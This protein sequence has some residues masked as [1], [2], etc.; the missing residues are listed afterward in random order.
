MMIEAAK[1]LRDHFGHPEFRPGQRESIEAT[2]QGRDV[3]AVMPTGSG[4][5]LCYQVP[6]LVRDGPAVVVSPLIALMKDQVDALQ[7]AGVAATFINS[8]IDSQE[9]RRRMEGMASGRWQLIYV[10]P[11]RLRSPTFRALLRRV[12]LGLLA[13]DEAH[14][15]SSWGHDFRPDYLRVGEMVAAARPAPVVACTATATPEVRDDIVRRL[16]LQ[17]PKVLVRGFRRDNLFLTVE[18][19]RGADDKIGRALGHLTAALAGEGSALVYCSTRKRS[20]EVADKLRRERIAAEAYHAGIA[21]EDRKGVQDRFM[22]GG[23]RCVVAT[24]AFG[25]GVDK[26]DVRLVIHHDLPGSPEAYYQEVGRAGRDGRPSR[27]VLLFNHG[28]LHVRRFLIEASN[29]PEEVVRQV[30]DVLA[31]EAE[32]GGGGGVVELSPIAIA[33]R[34]SLA[35]GDRQV[36]SAL[37]ALERAEL[38]E[39]GVPG[40]GRP[41]FQLVKRAP[42]AVD[43][44]LAEVAGA[45]RRRALLEALLRR[46]GFREGDAVSVDWGALAAEAGAEEASIRRAATALRGA[47]LVSVR[48]GFSGRAMLLRSGAEPDAVSFTALKERADREHQKLRRMTIYCTGVQCRHGFI[49][50]HFGDEEAGACGD[51]CDICTDAA[52]R[53]AEGDAGGTRR[54]TSA[55]DPGLGRQPEDLTDDQILSIRKA[56]SAVARLRGRYGLGRVAAVLTGGRDQK[57]VDAGLDQLPTYGALSRWRRADVL[58]LLESLVAAGCCEVRGQEYPLITLSELGAEVMHARQPPPLGWPALSATSAPRPT[59]QNPRRRG[60]PAS[61]DPPL[62]RE[63]QDLLDRL[64]QLRTA[65]ARD[66]S[67][68]AYVI[69]TDRTLIDMARQCPQDDA[70]LLQVHGIGPQKVERYGA[71]FLAAVRGQAPP[72]P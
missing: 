46:P 65:L 37:I 41:A 72:G 58:I 34:C 4:K 49:L 42:A 13:V 56:L 18:R 60:S 70:G 39:R 28:D 29:P 22:G 15:I 66:R 43:V 57:L 52:G 36:R 45:P 19:V 69:A 33:D 71:E 11:E 7:R 67:V 2:L 3:V 68:P 26:A 50:D 21:P 32:D 10:A 54:P 25:M 9:R 14:C 64:R 62:T 59:G 55:G 5:S 44:A 23:T 61:D 38:L 20:E 8:S 48:R 31:Q 17:T 12:P 47:G 24:N 1:A 51:S 6:A 63:A 53:Q 16:D 30:Y 40:D 27:C 35:K